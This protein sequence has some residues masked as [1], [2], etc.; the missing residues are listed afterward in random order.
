MEG[1]PRVTSSTWQVTPDTD[2]L[3]VSLCL[4]PGPA[5]FAALPAPCP[6]SPS[7]THPLVP[8]QLPGTLPPSLPPSLE[9]LLAPTPHLPSLLH[10]YLP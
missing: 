5:L 6:P 8:I 10:S 3:S 2:C 9:A 4:M 7:L 1:E